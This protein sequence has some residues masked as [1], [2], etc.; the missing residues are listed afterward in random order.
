MSI[1]L[2]S[3][4]RRKRVPPPS[5]RPRALPIGSRNAHRSTP[6]ACHPIDAITH[7]RAARTSS[8]ASRGRTLPAA[9][10]HSR[11][12]PCW[13]EPSVVESADEESSQHSGGVYRDGQR[14][15]RVIEVDFKGWFRRLDGARCNPLTMTDAATRML[16]RCNHFARG[17][18]N[19]VKPVFEGC[20]RSIQARIQHDQTARSARPMPTWRLLHRIDALVSARA[21]TDLQS[22]RGACPQRQTER[23]YQA[24]QRH[25]LPR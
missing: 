18:H 17:T 2:S 8:R 10:R 3:D 19:G 25:A 14:F 24:P 11:D 22:E 7:A 16:H 13:L 15:N 21:S 1:A 4:S 9:K 6:R 5:A 12:A 20:V 23:L